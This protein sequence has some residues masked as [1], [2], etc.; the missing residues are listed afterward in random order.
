ME[1]MYNDR[2][3]YK[4]R[5]IEAKKRQEVEPSDDNI[6]AIAQNHNMQLAKKIQLNSAYGALS[7]EYFRWYDDKLAESITLS[8]QLAI[9]WIER[10]MNTYLNKIFKTED[11]D[12]VLACDTDSMYITLESLV[13]QVGIDKSDTDAI[14]KFLDKVCERKFE[15]F[16]DASYERLGE[17]VNAYAQKMK[18]KREA[19]ADKGIWTAKKRYILN[20]YNNE[21]V[22]YAEP[23]LK[24]MGIEAVRSS[25]PAACRDLIKKALSIIMNNT[26]DDLIKFISKERTIFSTLP[27]EDV[28][29]PRGCKLYK[30]NGNNKMLYT[31]SDKGLPIHV[32]GALLYNEMLEKNKL[33]TR[34]QPIQNGDK[35]KFCYLKMPNPSMNNVIAC[36]NVLP[37]QFDLDI[38]ID[39]DTQFEK[40]FL[41]PIKTITNAIGWQ[42]EKVNSI[43]DFFS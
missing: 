24:M 43:E 15:P 4:D 41:D 26:Q 2:V 42:V 17:Y 16:I 35:I 34:Y 6:K 19:I 28:A 33:Q 10:D 9:K 3:V 8:G 11:I 27:F 1:K 23:K 13:D 21:G 31:L 36:A 40:S 29:F 30:T 25:T 39:Y 38:Y 20:V 14:V 37:K 5:M 18:M 32:R 12:Y 7:N 22:Q